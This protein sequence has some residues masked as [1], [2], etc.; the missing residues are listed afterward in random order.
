[1]PTRPTNRSLFVLSLA[2]LPLI[3]IKPAAASESRIELAG[4]VPVMC[5]AEIDLGGGPGRIEEFCNSPAGYEVYLDHGPLAAPASVTVD[6]V[7]LVLADAAS[8]LISSSDLAATRTRSI[9]FDVPPGSRLILR[10]VPR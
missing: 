3:Y 2:L 9:A 1:M 8:T 5:R 7:T 4:Q 10:V 6:G